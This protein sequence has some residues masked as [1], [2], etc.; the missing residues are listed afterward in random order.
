MFSV[1]C[2]AETRESVASTVLVVTNSTSSIINS[3]LV[4]VVELVLISIVN[5]RCFA[6]VTF[7]SGRGVNLRGTGGHVP[8][9]LEWGD[10]N[11]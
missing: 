2:G 3:L 7:D 6:A 5:L 4:L 9:N 11:V 8:Q 10:A 1:L